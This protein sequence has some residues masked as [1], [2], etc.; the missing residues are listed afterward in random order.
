MSV[1]VIAAY[2]R[3]K[4]SSPVAIRKCGVSSVLQGYVQEF[5][6]YATT[7]C[8]CVPVPVPVQI[9]RFFK[10]NSQVGRNLDG[11]KQDDSFEHEKISTEMQTKDIKQE[12]SFC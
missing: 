3:H 1:Y 4:N 11:K 6:K 9:E 8:V 7:L 12:P 5:P 2:R 10:F